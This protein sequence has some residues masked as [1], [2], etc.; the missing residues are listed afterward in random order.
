M[1]DDA[2]IARPYAKAIFEHALHENTLSDWATY[3]KQLAALI[4]IRDVKQFIANP[5][6]TRAQHLELLQTIIKPKSDDVNA[7]SSF[8]SLLAENNR[9]MFLPEVCR[10][11]ESYKTD[12][13]KT[14]EVDILSFA[15]ISKAQQEQLVTSL[16]ARLQRRVSLNIH[17]EPQLLGGAVILAGNLVIDGS[18][19]GKLNKLASGLT[20]N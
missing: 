5:V 1:S 12:Q 17:I 10:L 9:L 19:R 15:E 18:V 8:L 6:T 16:A 20:V 3:L 11:Y 7:L 13:E 4:L 2:T 14:L